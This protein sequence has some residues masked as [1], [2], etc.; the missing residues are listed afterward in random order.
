MRAPARAASAR[1]RATGGGARFADAVEELAEAPAAVSG[2]GPA[3][4]A[5]R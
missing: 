3:R 2:R 5:A 4:A 1:L